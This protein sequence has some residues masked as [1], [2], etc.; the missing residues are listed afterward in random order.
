MFGKMLDVG[1]HRS[2]NEAFWFYVT[3]M[4]L[5]IGISTFLVHILSLAGIVSGV[6]TFFEGHSVHTLIGTGFILIVSSLILTSR[7][8]TSDLLSIV[9]VVLGVYLGYT[10]SVILGM[11]PVALLT[12]MRA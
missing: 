3:S 2:V 12:T 8:L 5:L 9:L 11:I 7:K 6:G 10:T 1:T 4:I